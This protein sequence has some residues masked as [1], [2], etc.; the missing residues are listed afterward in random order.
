MRRPADEADKQQTG[1]YDHDHD[2]LVSNVLEAFLPAGRAP[3]YP[4]G[5]SLQH[6]R[7]HRARRARSCGG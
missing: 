6:A 7:A 2:D 1:V 5:S 4:T 3:V